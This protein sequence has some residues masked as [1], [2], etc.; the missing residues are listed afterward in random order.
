MEGKLV[1]FYLIIIVILTFSYAE[2][3]PM[4]SAIP[5]MIMTRIQEVRLRGRAMRRVYGFFRW[6]TNLA[7]G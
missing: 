5:S 3:G 1:L 2:V 4:K 6:S 7:I